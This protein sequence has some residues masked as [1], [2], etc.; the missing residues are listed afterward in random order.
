M[1]YAIIAPLKRPAYH[2]HNAIAYCKAFVCIFPLF[3]GLLTPAVVNPPLRHMKNERHKCICQANALLLN[4]GDLCA[5]RKRFYAS[6][7]VLIH[8][9][10]RIG[11]F[12]GQMCLR[13]SHISLLR[14][15]IYFLIR[16]RLFRVTPLL[17]NKL[18][19][20]KTYAPDVQR[21]PNDPK[22]GAECGRTALD[23]R[24]G[25]FCFTL[26]RLCCV[27]RTNSPARHVK[28]RLVNTGSLAEE[29]R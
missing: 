8:K 20:I 18:K 19:G 11:D 6:R 5:T 14:S 22:L 26:S 12:G 13:V 4:G 27:N 3:P 25:L 17:R 2:S 16:N 24:S 7:Q 10:G 21:S 28:S 9:F 29:T 15:D 1:A 23:V